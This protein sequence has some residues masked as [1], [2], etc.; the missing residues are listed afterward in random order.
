MK[1]RVQKRGLAAIEAEQY[2]DL[3]QD[4]L[5]QT[6][7]ELPNVVV[8]FSLGVSMKGGIHNFHPDGGGIVPVHQG[9]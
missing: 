3:R 4:V 1:F 5:G 6:L 9:L 2:G 7:Q 8:P